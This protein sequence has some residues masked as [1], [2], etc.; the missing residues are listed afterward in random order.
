MAYGIYINGV[1]SQ[2][3]IQGTV[4]NGAG[5]NLVTTTSA[6]GNTATIPGCAGGWIFNYAYGEYTL[7]AGSGANGIAIF[8][9]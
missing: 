6:T 9:W 3:V 2:S 7:R 1:Q 5:A 8:S 4:A